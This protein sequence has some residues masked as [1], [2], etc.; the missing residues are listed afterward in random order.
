MKRILFFLLTIVLVGNA[1][2]DVLEISLP[3]L[4]GN[5]E[6]GWQEPVTAPT[7]RTI[8]FMFPANIENLEEL[9]FVLSGTW[10]E[11]EIVCSNSFGDPPD[12]TSF[13]PYLSAHIS[14]SGS[15]SEFFYTTIIPPN[16]EFSEWSAVF[17]A[18][19]QPNLPSLNTLLGLEVTMEV[20]C[21]M[22]LI[23]PCSVTTDSEG[24][25]TD[26]RLQALG[27]VPAEKSTWGSVK[28]MYR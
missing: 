12:S 27:T 17:E 15:Y 23:L 26:V 24:T 3:G 8:T 25:L 4:I 9:R 21:D 14:A 7:S 5:Y 13:T 2:A 11:G 19:C 22:G 20:I 1:S 6:T 18:C 28:S 10:V 16:G